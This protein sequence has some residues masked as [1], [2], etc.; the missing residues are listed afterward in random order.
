M[1]VI[2]FFLCF[3]AFQ[4]VSTRFYGTFQHSDLIKEIINK[5]GVTASADLIEAIAAETEGLSDQET[6]E[7]IEGLTIISCEKRLDR[8]KLA[9]AL[10]AIGQNRCCSEN[11]ALNGRPAWHYALFGALL[12]IA[13]SCTLTALF[14]RLKPENPSSFPS[15]QTVLAPPA[16]PIKIAS[17]VPA[18]SSILGWLAY[19]PV[20][21]FAYFWSFIS[22]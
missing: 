15:G 8:T 14:Y 22:S 2:L 17:Q 3:S 5:K 12:G 13:S 6:A 18:E 16:T 11:H 1:K 19:Q 4:A 20:R 21:P 9:K 7:L 10:L